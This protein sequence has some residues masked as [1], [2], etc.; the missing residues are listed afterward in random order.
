[1]NYA[2]KMRQNDINALNEVIAEAQRFIKI[3]ERAKTKVASKDA[4]YHPTYF[5]DPKD[6]VYDVPHPELAAVKRS[7]LDLWRMLAR[8]RR[9]NRGCSWK[10][11]E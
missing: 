10:D 3:A 1:M 11:S 2:E 6:M 8:Y 5:P 7:S 9:H 4:V